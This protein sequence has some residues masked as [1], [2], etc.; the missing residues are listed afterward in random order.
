MSFIVSLI[1]FILFYFSK[2]IN[3]LK[4][5]DQIYLNYYEYSYNLSEISLNLT[6]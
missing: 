3:V 4:E 1:G 5:G 6:N 2:E